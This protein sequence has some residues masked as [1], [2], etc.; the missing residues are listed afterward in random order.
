MKQRHFLIVALMAAVTFTA[1]N[2]NDEIQ[3]DSA[4]RFT[5]G[6][7]PVAA[8]GPE[9]RAAGTVW[10]NGD[11][12]GIFMMQSGSAIAANKQYTTDGDGT[13]TAAS[14]DEMYYP[15]NGSTVDFIAYSPIKAVRRWQPRST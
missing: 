7:D 2:V 10:G 13:F 4:V 8:T 14:G 3:E 9:T 6:I 15:M 1:C 12:I 5:A 11:A